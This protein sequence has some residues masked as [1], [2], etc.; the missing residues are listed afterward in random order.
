[1]TGRSDAEEE[2]PG[3]IRCTEHYLKP[4]WT[5]DLTDFQNGR[6]YKSVKERIPKDMRKILGLVRGFVIEL[7]FKIFTV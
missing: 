7:F 5:K 4:M 6:D 2:V 3:W 1:V